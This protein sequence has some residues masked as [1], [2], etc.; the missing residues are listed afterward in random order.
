M[1][2]GANTAGLLAS[3]PAWE[4]ASPRWPSVLG[5]SHPAPSAR[6][7]LPVRCPT[8]RTQTD[9]RAPLLDERTW[10]TIQQSG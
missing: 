10:P 8:T 9:F 6:L 4:S 1:G 3:G 7:P 2:P 5:N